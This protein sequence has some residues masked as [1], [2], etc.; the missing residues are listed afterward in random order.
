MNIDK[1]NTEIPNSRVPGNIEYSVPEITMSSILLSVLKRPWVVLFSLLVILIPLAYYLMN[2]IPE[3]ESKAS[4]MVSIK[5]VSFLDAV[6][7]VGS[8]GSPNRTQKY[9]TSILDSREYKDD[10]IQQVMASY[11]TIP[12][13]SMEDVVRIEYKENPREEGFLTISAISQDKKFALFLAEAAVDNFRMRSIDLE[14]QDAKNVSTFIEEQLTI[15]NQKLEKA[16][17][18]VQNFL[19]NNKFIASD[20]EM[21]VG[22]ELFDMEKKLTEAEAGLEM[23]KMNIDSYDRQIKDILAQLSATRGGELSE[24]DLTSKNRLDEIRKTLDNSVTLELTKEQIENLRKERNQIINKYVKSITMSS[25]SNELSDSYSGM[26]LLNLE[27]E[28]ET[29]LVEEERY[30]NE[31]NFYKI[32]IDRFMEQHPD[33]SKDV[34]EYASLVRARDVLKSTIDI[35]LEKREEARI[36]IASEQG[37]IKII[38]KPRLPKEP[39]PQKKALKL[40]IGIL[41]ALGLGISICVIVDRFDD[42]VKDET[43]IA[44]LGLPVFG[45]I[46]MLVQSKSVVDSFSKMVQKNGKPLDD[47]KLLTGYSEKSPISEAYRGIK[48]NLSFIAKDKNK[49]VFVVTS[50]SSS[51]G[52]S[53]TTANLAISF[54]QGGKKTLIIDCDLRRATQHKYYKTERKP[55]LTEYFYDEAGWDQIVKPT[56]LESLSIIT[57]GSTPINPA[58]LLGSATMNKFLNYIRPQ[59]DI[60]LIDTPPIMACV[61]SRILAEQCDGMIIIAKVESTS[62]KALTHAVNITRQLNVDILGIILNQIE[63]RYGYGYYYA[64]RYYNPY[65]YYYSGYSYYYQED[66]ITGERIKK[67]RKIDKK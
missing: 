33:I 12:A 62:A 9:Y 6:S 36:R 43:S 22:Q 34:L 26:T 47:I 65:S 14:R 21:G 29:S 38:D 42:S 3:Y 46:P 15:M 55:G 48:T 64:Y 52:K 16:Q 37:G 11:P 1:I 39:I 28:L 53:L 13:D 23:V 49:K 5:G 41:A 8:S 59:F 19:R 10:I 4:V 27:S 56:E 57:A 54:A 18:S 31:V 17:E 66:E 32:Q 2:M 60:I 44:A 40:I 45:M 7:V 67:R 35:L 51:E 20:T 58:E 30:K 63:K 25:P 61:D 50:P 24:V